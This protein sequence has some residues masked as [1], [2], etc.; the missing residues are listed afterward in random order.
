MP[1]VGEFVGI[2]AEFDVDVR[3][4]RVVRGEFLGDCAGGVRREP[5][6]LIH[7]DE[8]LEFGLGFLD[9]FASLLVQ[10]CLLGVALGAHRH[11]LPEC[12]RQC[13][14]DE[15]G[16][17]G[18]EDRCAIDR[19]GRHPDHDA[20]DRDDAVVGAEH[21]GAQPVQLAVDRT[22]VRFGGMGLGF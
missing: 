16:D 2:N 7:A 10:Q 19:G 12:H 21:S 14:G 6:G 17:P 15:S 13:A 1:G 18:G 9:E 11:V 4:E 5:L 3:G 8:F 20:G 22:D